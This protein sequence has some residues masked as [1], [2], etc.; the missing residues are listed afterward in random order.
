ME[1]EQALGEVVDRAIIL[2]ISTKRLSDPQQASE[3]ERNLS[4]LMT[5]WSEHGHVAMETLEEFAPL[6][7][8][9]NN[10]WTVETELRRHES[11]RDFG[12]R[13]VALARSVYRLND[14]R[15]ALKRA[16]SLRLGSRLIEEKSY[17]E[18]TYSR[19]DRIEK[20]NSDTIKSIK[21]IT[22]EVTKCTHV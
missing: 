5:S 2:R 1:V 17:E 10:L 12:E 4:A 9:N 20:G 19:S 21:D 22:S 8:V 7:E 13:F 16:I 14:R 15:A 11:R 6:T 18:N 3:A